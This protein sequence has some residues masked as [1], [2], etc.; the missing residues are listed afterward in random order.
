MVNKVRTIN[1][2]PEIFQT[3]TNERFLSAS[4]D[5]LTNQPDFRRVEGF[6]GNRYGNGVNPSDKYVVE[7]NKK[8]INYQLTPGVVFCKPETQVAKDFI[9]YSGI[10]DSLTLNNAD[11][12]QHDRLFE[13]EFYSWDPFI[14]YDKIA[15]Y[16]EYF[17]IPKGPDAITITNREVYEQETYSVSSQDNGV[18]FIGVSG[19]N[20]N[21]IMLRG[22]TYT[23]NVPYELGQFYIQTEPGIDVDP[24]VRNVP[25][26]VNNGMTTD[27]APII[28]T[29]PDESDLVY[30]K[31][32]YQSK[33]DINSVGTITLITSNVNNVFDVNDIL[34]KKNYTSPKGV[35]FTNGLKVK[36]E[37]NAIPQEYTNGEY[38]V[39]GV[40]T[41]I[42]LLNA[43][44]FLSSTLGDKPVYAQWQGEKYITNNYDVDL[45]LPINP[46]YITIERNS[47]D[48]NSWSRGN[49]W[50][51]FQVLE[52]TRKFL[53]TVTSDINNTITRA[54]RPIIEYR[55]NLKL[56]NSGV[57]SLG[58]VN[59]IDT[60]TEDAFSTIEGKT[61]EQVGLITGNML[62]PGQRIIFAG[63]KNPLVRKSIYFVT[64]VNAGPN[65]TD[66]VSLSKDTISNVSNL[67]QVFCLE[68]TGVIG[69]SW[70]YDEVSQK[71]FISQR[72]NKINQYPLYDIFDKNGNSLS[73]SQY[74]SG[75]TFRGTKLFSFTDGS[76]IDDPVLGFP[77][78]YSSPST[79]GDIL[80]TVNYNDD[81]YG[82][83]PD[84]LSNAITAKINNGYVYNYFNETSIEKLNGWVAAAGHSFQYQVFEFPTIENFTYSG[85]NTVISFTSTGTLFSY[86]VGDKLKI[87]G[88]YLGGTSPENDLTFTISDI[89]G[90]NVFMV[91]TSSITGVCAVTNG[92]FSNIP[93]ISLTGDGEFAEVSV[94]LLGSGT[95]SFVCDVPARIESAWRTVTVYYDGSVLEKNDYHYIVNQENL[96]TTVTVDTNIGSKVTVLLLSDYASTTGYYQ[97]PF[98]LENNPFNDNITT[99]TVGDIRNQYTTIFNNAPDVSGNTYG[100]NNFHDLG[101]LYKYGTSI[102]QNS[103]SLVLPG[104]FLRKNDTNIFD[105]LQFNKEQYEIYKGLLIKLAASG[106]YSIYQNPS[107]ILDD[108]IFKISS[109]KNKNDSF[110]WS[111]M[112]FSGTPYITNNYTFKLDIDNATFSLSDVWSKTMFSEANYNSLGVYITSTINAI[113]SYRQL[114]KN[115]D[116]TISEEFPSLQ[117]N[118]KIKAGDI[119]TVKEYNQTYGSYCPSTP[120]KL[121]L[122][123]IFV[124]E[125]TLNNTYLQPTYFVKGHDGSLTKL[126]GEYDIINQKLTDFRDI[127]L[128]EFENRVYNNY[129]VTGELPLK[130]TDIIPGEFRTTNFTQSEILNLHNID[131]LNWVGTNK[132]D[133]KTQQFRNNNQFTYNYSESTNKLSGKPLQQGYWR[134]IYKWLYDTDN[135]ASA[136][137]EMLGLSSKPLWW[138]SRYGKAPYTSSNTYMWQDIADGYVYNDGDPYIATERIRPRLLEILPVDTLGN[139]LS[140]FDSIVG[141]YNKLT[142]QKNWQAGDISPAE[143]AYIKSS[144]YPFDLMKTY[145]LTQPNKFFNLFC[146]L[147]RYKFNAQIGQFL[148]DEVYHLNAK[149]IEVYGSGTAKH[150]YINWVVDYN[151]YNGT[152]GKLL[153]SEYLKN[154]DVRLIYQMSGFTSKNYLKFLVEKATPN[155]S[156]TSLLIPDENYSVLLY[157]NPPNDTITYSSV[158]IQ[159]VR[160]GYAVWGNSKNKQYFTIYQPTST[161]KLIS[162]NGNSV[163][164]STEFNISKKITIPYGNVFYS[165]QAV[166]EFLQSYGYYLESKGVKFET[167][168]D[169]VKSD[170]EKSIKQFILWSQQ[171]WDLGSVISLN[172]NAT[173]FTIEKEGSIV[174]PLTMYK[175]NF[176][177]NQNLIPLQSQDVLINRQDQTFNV[178]VLSTGDTVAFTNLNMHSIEHAI[179]FDNATSFNDIIYNLPTGL[180]QSRILLLG[181]KTNQWNGYVDTSGFILNENNVK[182]WQPNTRYPKNIIVFYKNKYYSAK[183]LIEPIAEFSNEDWIETEYSDIKTGLLPNPNTSAYESSLFYDTTKANL[184]NDADLLAFSLIGFRPRNY[185]TSA[186]LSDITQVNVYKNILQS[187]G[188]KLLAN[189]FK[190][191]QFDQGLIDYSIQENWAIKTGEFGSILNNNFVEFHLEP[192]ILSGNPTLIGFN[193]DGSPITG[194]HQVVLIDQLSNFERRPITYDFLPEYNK[195]YTVENGLPSAGYVNLSDTKF[196]V[197]KFNNLNEDS[198]FLDTLY[199]NNIIWIANQNNDWD[200]FVASTLNNQITQLDNNLNGTA[201]LTFIRPHYL[202]ENDLIA[203]LNFN[204]IVN[205]F[206]KVTSI[207][208]STAILI[209]IIIDTTIT[210]INGTGIG[211]KL[212]S[213]RFEQPSQIVD[214]DIS[215]SE[216]AYRKIWADFDTNNQ[217]SVYGAGPMF[218][219]KSVLTNTGKFAST[220]AYNN[221]VKTMVANST[222]SLFRYVNN[223]LVQTVAGGV[224]TNTQVTVINEFVYCS[225]PNENKI[226][227]YRLNSLLNVLEIFQVIDTST[228]LTKN[229]GAIAVSKDNM[230]LYVSD[231][232]NQEIAMYNYDSDTVKYIYANSITDTNVPAN[233]NWGKSL[234]TS[235]DG[236]KIIVGAPNEDIGI[237]NDAGAVY[238]YTR[239]VQKFYADGNTDT[240][241]TVV[242]APNNRANV[243]VNNILNFSTVTVSNNNVTFIT[244]PDLGTII[245]VSTAHTYFVNRFESSSPHI[246][247]L[248]GNSVDTNRYGAEIIVGAPY[249]LT[250]I[251]DISDV[252]GAVYRYTNSGQRYGVVECTF[253]GTRIGTIIVDGYAVTYSGTI[254]EI[255]DTINQQTPTNIIASYAENTLTITVLKNT[256]EVLYNILDVTGDSS[257]LSSLNI[258]SYTNTQII[259]NQNKTNV[260]EF[261]FTV[262]MN[263]RDSLI[264]SATTDIKRHPT[265]FD[266]TTYCKENSTIFDN[267]LTIFVDTF[268]NQGVVSEYTYVPAANENIANA[269]KY[270]F[271]QFIETR[272]I[273]E[274]SPQPR[275][276][277]SLWYSDNLIFV[278]TPNWATNTGGIVIYDT[279]YDPI[280][281]CHDI[282]S[283]SWYVDKQQLPAVNI[284]SISNISIFS[285]SNNETLEY[286]DYID[287]LQGKLLGAI[288]DNL[289]YLDATDPAVYAQEGLSWTSEHVGKT[290]LDLTTIRLLN[291]HQPD[292]AYN[293]KNWGKAFP[294][295]TADVYTWIE[296]IKTPINYSG[297]GFPVSFNKYTS[298]TTL[299]KAT[300]SLVTKYYF[301]VKNY[302]FIPKGKTL[303]PYVLSLY[304]LN[305]ISAGISYLAPLTTNSIALYNSSDAIN[306]DRSALHLGY[307]LVNGVENKHVNWALIRNDN[308]DDFLSGFPYS[309]NGKPTGLYLKFLESFAG[310]DNYNNVVPDPRL[311]ERLKYGTEF[312]PN[313]S[314]FVDRQLA[315]KN[316]LAYAN[317]ILKKLPIVELRDFEL[318]NTH[319]ETFDTRKYWDIVDWYADGYDSS[320]KPDL[321]A[322]TI[323]DLQTISSE[324]L[325]TSITG[326]NI[327]LGNGLIVKVKNNKYNNSELYVYNDSNPDLWDR[328]VAYGSTIQFSPSLYDEPYGFSSDPF[329]E[330]YDKN[331]AKETTNIIR[332]LN[333]QCYVSDLLIERNNSLILMFN[334]IQ[335]ENLSQSNYLTWLNKTSLVDVI[336]KIRNLSPF[337]NYQRDNQEFLEG[338]L[339]EVKPYHVVIKEFIFS[340]EGSDEYYYNISDFDL[341]SKYNAQIGKLITPQLSY[342][343]ENLSADSFTPEDKIWQEPQYG[344]WFAN[345]GLSISNSEVTDYYYSELVNDIASNATTL[346]LNNVNGLPVT[347]TVIID[348]EYISYDSIDYRN[349]KL[350]GLGRGINGTVP[351]SHLAKTTVRVVMPAVVVL[352]SGRGYLEPPRII[353]VIDEKYIYPRSESILSPILA[354]GKLIGVQV[355][356]PGSGYAVTPKIVISPSS[357][358]N[359]F[360]STNVNISSNIITI[361]DH[362]FLNSDYVVFNSVEGQSSPVGLQDNENYYIRVID[363]NQISLCNDLKDVYNTNK[364]LIPNSSYVSP[365]VDL[366]SQGSGILSVTAKASCFTT[367]QPV[368]EPKI[369]IAF[370][371]VSYDYIDE[372]VSGNYYGGVLPTIPTPSPDSANIELVIQKILY[373]TCITGTTSVVFENYTNKIMPGQLN[374]QKVKFIKLDTV[375]N[376]EKVYYLKLVSSNTF[377]VYKDSLYTTIVNDNEFVFSIGEKAY[378]RYPVEVNNSVVFYKNDIYECIISNNDSEFDS[379]KWKKIRASAVDK[380][381]GYYKPTESMPGKNLPQ[382]LRGIEYENLTYVGAVF[383]PGWDGTLF[384]EANVGYDGIDYNPTVDTIIDYND[385]VETVETVNILGGDFADGYGP[386]ELACGLVTDKLVMTVFVKTNNSDTL[387]NWKFKLLVDDMN[388]TN[389]YSNTNKLVNSRWNNRWWYGTTGNYPNTDSTANTTMTSSIN[390]AAVILRS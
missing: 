80:F 93:V 41:S 313:Q 199:R 126:F 45:Y 325:Y 210:K 209:D 215:F 67:S 345:Y 156:N 386:E 109:T 235:N 388:V 77:I 257:D 224:G 25:G 201:T 222:G 316:Y 162:V 218:K 64:F 318:L 142:F 29:V 241:I 152:D 279:N 132:I 154:L 229:S 188:T 165:V 49:R 303:S 113:Q 296:S 223:Q 371:R 114:Q 240:F 107:D 264:I 284:N 65:G 166:C 255:T 248:F 291:Y 136:P 179:V 18:T 24:S 237:L 287:P 42:V 28:F 191:A 17:W 75:T 111:D 379:D 103:G 261:G 196:Q 361:T 266:F 350:I 52:T 38:Y 270:V 365:I 81:T 141:N 298:A 61:S 247:G 285:T 360:T 160:D 381:N 20:P 197:Y 305:P 101:P 189:S 246:G 262:K 281:K 50:F 102:I 178:K 147:D 324:Q 225:S 378:L 108:I 175:D 269:G 163:S 272:S 22:G 155:S 122:Y 169:G 322:N 129:K 352:E 14:N 104:L 275:F 90:N 219:Q 5:V 385:S 236:V 36:F 4:L 342:S 301:W 263:E 259:Y 214:N 153:V 346:T 157:D 127:V 380:I 3:K 308:I 133:F 372:W 95:T 213:Q 173:E 221:I 357:L 383:N 226:Y 309:T 355:D 212:I 366:L 170:F 267:D 373:C 79:I 83:N 148:Y 186:D 144:S 375:K 40:G 192:N 1:F 368:R 286:L 282:K 30:S 193:L 338:F 206:Y 244:K 254:S 58:V 274:S 119:I 39:E 89:I 203:I 128:F 349:S 62:S 172:P 54:R 86:N 138:N 57:K 310:F 88:T 185:L 87:L 328:I 344:Q 260:S 100:F 312:K 242:N 19:V 315:L 159:I 220:L 334:Y 333:E 27:G 84:S 382:L 374:G 208:S 300:N 307:G 217:W 6:I 158:I 276:G 280:D 232:D 26:V 121:G 341:P 8:R 118:F 389:L 44:S 216:W 340:Y 149:N 314:M 180:R 72:K 321:E 146:D 336:H 339:N 283:T 243:Y 384:D 130:S 184:E 194:V 71:W 327:F 271:G 115:I 32:Y 181:Q 171:K 362:N 370:D 10:I 59:L 337:K 46:E 299:D 268:K 7:P 120:S 288:T 376:I 233:S 204:S 150:S 363:S 66:I 245:T 9:N 252:E 302:R 330:V 123:P 137:W 329:G 258:S 15:N 33:T 205:G 306:G 12:A 70:W 116:Y 290:W 320:V 377:E 326:A 256:P 250:P 63:D 135:P 332:W 239:L 356:N 174:Q 295:S 76:G 369:T 319:D 387:H 231:S 183:K 92:I 140:P 190:N 195:N 168:V 60:S 164:I 335:S 55:A 311:P 367:S 202:E 294:G 112:I 51:H 390:P 23:I 207:V 353:A 105:A 293:A 35:E 187:K 317:Q 69:T 73:D 85:S 364:N 96:T 198:N 211:F 74:Y 228:A 16:S 354:N 265:T 53:G 151:Y 99:V 253:T 358:S 48:L 347:G 31:L 106:D 78:S 98:T 277:T 292:L 359:T 348:N 351:T 117:I 47:N 145:V 125:I 34:H 131:F 2:L 238:I 110:F 182:D 323:T 143:S 161:T 82:Y 249:E 11:T 304:I 273:P 167:I 177:L 21:I 176:I 297:S 56:I 200:V 230:W 13:S 234:A 134:G 124:P 43:D 97:V 278:G 343:F 227:V 91:D 331:L 289:D 37:S 251:K 94:T 139:L 68:S